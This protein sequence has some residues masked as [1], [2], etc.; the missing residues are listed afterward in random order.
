MK[1]DYGVIVFDSSPNV[2]SFGMQAV[3]DSL[4]DSNQYTICGYLGL[5][6][7]NGQNLWKQV[8]SSS[9]MTSFTND[10]LNDMVSGQSGSP[11]YGADNKV[12]GIVTYNGGENIHYEDKSNLENTAN[13]INTTVFNYLMKYRA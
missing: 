5:Q 11:L 1:Y 8:Y 4:L 13:R 3:K 6:Y 10:Y 9:Y 7:G 12:I 2:G